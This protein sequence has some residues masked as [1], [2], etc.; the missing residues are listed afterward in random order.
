MAAEIVA[1]AVVGVIAGIAA[2]KARQAD[3]NVRPNGS[4]RTLMEL[5][6]SLEHQVEDLTVKVDHLADWQG[7]HTFDHNQAHPIWLPRTADE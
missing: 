4:K 7:Q 5:A 3:K 1:D 2:W 6:E